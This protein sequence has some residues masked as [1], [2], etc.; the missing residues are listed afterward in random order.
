METYFKTGMA[1]NYINRLDTSTINWKLF[2]FY[3][4]CTEKFV[5]SLFIDKI[6]PPMQKQTV[7][8]SHQKKFLEI[9]FVS[10]VQVEKYFIEENFLIYNV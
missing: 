1:F 5:S 2:T 10:V 8:Y 3:H 6:E 9:S 7:N 4:F